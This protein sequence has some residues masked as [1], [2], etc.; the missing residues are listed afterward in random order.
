MLTLLAGLM[1]FGA[2]VAAIL[3]FYEFKLFR[4]WTS[5]GLSIALIY[6]SSIY[7][8]FAFVPVAAEL[9]TILARLGFLTLLFALIAERYY[10]LRRS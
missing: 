1:A 5:L 4:T 2:S 3:F 9:R 10:R 8:W 6:I 7:L